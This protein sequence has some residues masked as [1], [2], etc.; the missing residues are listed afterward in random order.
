MFLLA[1]LGIEKWPFS[2]VLVEDITAFQPVVISSINAPFRTVDV[3]LIDAPFMQLPQPTLI[4]PDNDCDL[5][6]QSYWTVV[7]LDFAGIGLQT[8]KNTVVR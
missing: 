2:S 1:W 4:V 3:S 6:T 7:S 8:T 5:N